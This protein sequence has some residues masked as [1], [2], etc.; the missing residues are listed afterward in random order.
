[1]SSKS[2]YDKTYN[3]PLTWSPTHSQNH[4]NEFHFP[5]IKP[6]FKVIQDFVRQGEKP[7][8]VFQDSLSGAR[9]ACEEYG[10]V[11]CQVVLAPYAIYSA[12]S[13]AY[14]MCRQVEER[15]WGEILPQV[16]AKAERD[17]YQ[18]LVKPFINPARRELGLKEWRLQDLPKLQSSPAIMALFPDWLK[19]AP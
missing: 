1:V 12:L 7:L 11:S 10:L 4:Y 2:A 16:K 19:P 14:P 13:P 6:T 15:L 18:R 17:T 5:A 9:M 8:V 3:S